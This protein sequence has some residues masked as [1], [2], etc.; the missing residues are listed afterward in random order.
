MAH[1]SSC[2]QNVYVINIL[3]IVSM[4]FIVAVF[5]AATP[6][7]QVVNWTYTTASEDVLDVSWTSYVCSV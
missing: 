5:I 1:S 3:Y 4:Y 2:Q 6:W 7:T